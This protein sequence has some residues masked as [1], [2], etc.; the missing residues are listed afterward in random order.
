MPPSYNTRDSNKKENVNNSKINIGIEELQIVISDIINK[1]TESLKE[2]IAALKSEIC[3]LKSILSGVAG[4]NL[5]KP[6]DAKSKLE[7]DITNL[8]LNTSSSSSDTI[9]EVTNQGHGKRGKSGKKPTENVETAKKKDRVILGSSS[10]DSSADFASADQQLWIYVGRCRP[11]TTEEHIHSYLN[12][13][14]PGFVF[15]ITK[16]ASKGKNTSFR[17]GVSIALKDKIY[18]PTYW[19]QN[20]I[21]KRFKF[22]QIKKHTDT[23]SFQGFD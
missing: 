12:K 8:L 7:N 3:E 23:G 20:I 15:D 22:F 6:S 14:S 9:V 5:M 1:S 10:T 21:V 4:G 11:G 17:V 13:Q 16:L 2:E 18:D 19:P